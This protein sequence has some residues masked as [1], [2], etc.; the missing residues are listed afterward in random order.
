VDPNNPNSFWISNEYVANNWWQTS[1]ARVAI[2][3]DSGTLTVTGTSMLTGTTTVNAT[4]QLDGGSVLENKGT[5]NWIGGG[6]ALG[7]VTGGG[8]IKNDAGANFN[9]QTDGAITSGL[10][11]NAFTNAGA[12]T[13][14]VTGGVSTIGAPFTN[15]GT[16]NVQTGT[17]VLNGS[18]TF[19]GSASGAGTLVFGGGT[20]ALGSGVNL[21]VANLALSG[22]ATVNQGGSLSYAGALSEGTGT[23]LGVGAPTLTL[24][25][26]GASVAG[27]TAAP[28][29]VSPPGRCRATLR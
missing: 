13:K 23:T 9:V 12:L 27:A 26:T 8:T 19:G 10:G 17:L 14:S 16:V 18:G 5:L 24:N 6:F 15:T 11:T 3:A 4:V 1:V 2:G 20:T 22:G 25:G 28:A 7:P 21:T 29:W